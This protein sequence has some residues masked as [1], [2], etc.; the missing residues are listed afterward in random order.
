MTQ[1]GPVESIELF[2]QDVA[3]IDDISV[4]YLGSSLLN[5]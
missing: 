1:E 5:I 2:H 4:G 3:S